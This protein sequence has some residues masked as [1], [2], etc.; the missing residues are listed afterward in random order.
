M[1]P[2]TCVS[3][4]GGRSQQLTHTLL[5]EEAPNVL[6]G[7]GLRG[8]SKSSVSALISM[9]PVPGLGSRLLGSLQNP[10][11]G[12]RLVPIGMSW[13][14]L[15]IAFIRKKWNLKPIPG[16]LFVVLQFPSHWSKMNPSTIW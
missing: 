2:G 10:T 12:K 15:G 4:P 6:A 1:L 8:A 5:L 13:V 11:L 9:G 16:L 7:T 3:C 14:V